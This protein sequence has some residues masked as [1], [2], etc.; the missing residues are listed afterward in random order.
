[1]PAGPPRC[2]V[3]PTIAPLS[4]IEFNCWTVLPNSRSQAGLVTPVGMARWSLGNQHARRKNVGSS[5]IFA[6]RKRSGALGPQS[7]LQCVPEVRRTIS[8][9]PDT[10]THCR[11]QRA[12]PGEAGPYSI[13]PN[14]LDMQYAKTRRS[15]EST[16]VPPSRQNADWGSPRCKSA[17]CPTGA[18]QP[19]VCRPAQWGQ[20]TGTVL[21]SFLWAA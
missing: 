1:M 9:G 5:R 4:I 7:S 11:N 2:P 13:A 20:V 19:T 14:L 17:R 12:E 18:L 8:E 6:E 21:E 10:V 3:G 15:G 16:E